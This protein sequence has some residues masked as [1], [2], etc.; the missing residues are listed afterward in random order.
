[1]N[2]IQRADPVLQRRAILVVLLGSLIGGAAIE[3]FGRYRPGM[4]RWLLS[5]PAR[6][7][8]RE[9]LVLVA[10]ALATV[11]PLYA[12]AVYFWISG[13]RVHQHQRFPVEGSRLIR[14]SP[15]LRGHAATVRGRVIQ[16]LALVLAL[17]ASALAVA[18]WRLATVI[19]S[20]AA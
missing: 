13:G 18:W 5:D 9:T 14:D 7:T 17:L 10:L 8:E 19:I 15:I 12:F 6:V 4:G 16:G 20:R 3:G 2:E 11:A 1:M